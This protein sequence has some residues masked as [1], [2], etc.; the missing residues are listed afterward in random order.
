MLKFMLTDIDDNELRARVKL[1]GNLLG[2][3]IQKQSGDQVFEAI[4]T[5]RTGYIELRKQDDVN[6]R[7][8]LMDYIIRLDP[9]TLTQVVRAFSLYFSLVNIAE[10][11]FQHRQRRHQVHEG[12]TL[13]VGSFDHTL[14][15][16]H[17]QGISLKQLQ[18][19]LS[20]LSYT[21]V[22]TAHPTESKRR[23]F[24]EA[25]R[26]IFVITEKL[27]NPQLNKTER[28]VIVQ[29]LET[30]IQILW[31]TNEVR[32]NRPK[33]EDEIK[34]GLYY[35]QE[36]LFEAVPTVYRYLEN[37]VE[38][39]YQPAENKTTVQIPS[40]LHFGSWIGG[41]RDGN[42]YVTPETTQYAVLFHAR[43]VLLMYIN[44]ITQ[45]SKLLS[46]SDRMCKIS[47]DLN[48]S[49][50][51]DSLFEAE[52]AGTTGA[53][54]F[55]DNMERFRNEPYRH[56]LYFM[57]DRLNR[58]LN[59][60]ET[61]LAGGNPDFVVV[62]P[63]LPAPATLAHPCAAVAPALPAP[64][65][66]ARP[67]AAVAPALPAPTTFARPCAAGYLSEKEF[68]QDLYLI[69]DS[70]IQHGDAAV[71]K[72]ELQDLIRLA[73]TFGFYLVHL[74]LRQES[75]RHTA[76]VKEILALLTDPVDYD[77]LNE[78]QRLALLGKR[79]SNNPSPNIPL[80]SLTP[81]TRE[82]LAVFQ[83]MAKMRNNISPQIFGNYIISMTHEASHVM[84]VLYLAHLCELA[85]KNGTQWYSHIR[86]S[87]LFET[88]QDLHR[89]EPVLE[90]LFGNKVYNALLKAS[91][92]L[93][94][95]MLGYSDSCK[96][97]GILSSSWSLYKAQITIKASQ[98]QI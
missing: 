75:T 74:D 26:R 78:E 32:E 85:G 4:E 31:K 53:P 38:N 8:R 51:T 88:I 25:L 68:L 5:L 94:E 97:G 20:Y 46:Y 13:W 39:V 95:I 83:V 65:T 33:V 6:L 18:K 36:S 67:C 62:A 47:A 10:E 96:D 80:Q 24:L 93:Q 29:D 30:K 54:Q 76:A 19:L 56:K 9:E 16:F 98:L 72:A 27:Y 17:H 41:D 43:T 7:Q 91:G 34:N 79:L 21:P 60:I 82:T 42:P 64:A 84:E 92:N 55:N 50:Q 89:I 69:R 87:P 66:F 90:T 81:E 71:A 73:E 12:G 70:L 63:A 23:T 14:K 35:F 77:K 45:L 28:D 40:F 1:F 2:N 59:L 15:E 57:K 49:I 11:A 61:Q 37:A 44:R 3:V 86:I 48:H 52:S 22:F 58:N